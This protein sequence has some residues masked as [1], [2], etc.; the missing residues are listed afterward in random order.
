VTSDGGLE[1]PQL[2]GGKK[3]LGRA[4]PAVKHPAINVVM[5]FDYGAA[6]SWRR[7]TEGHDNKRYE[8]D[9]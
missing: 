1:I 7:L 3:K 2:S 6:S 9:H 4:L 8:M 5:V